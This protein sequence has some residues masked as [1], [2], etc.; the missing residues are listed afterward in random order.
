MNCQLCEKPI[1]LN[2]DGKP[3][4]RFVMPK[5]WSKTDDGKFIPSFRSLKVHKDCVLDLLESKGV[6]LRPLV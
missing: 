5:S 2:D 6:S 4:G 1:E 3:M